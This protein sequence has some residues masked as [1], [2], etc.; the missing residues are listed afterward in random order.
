MAVKLLG[1]STW[2]TQLKNCY[3]VAQG[4]QETDF[5]FLYGSSVSDVEKVA[6]KIEMG[7]KNR[8]KNALRELCSDKGIKAGDIILAYKGPAC[9]QICEV[10][11]DFT[12]VY[13]EQDLDGKPIN[14]YGNGLFPVKW[15]D[16]R[17]VSN[18]YTPCRTADDYG[19]FGIK[20]WQNVNPWKKEDAQE[21]TTRWE[22]YKK[23]NNF[24]PNDFPPEIK[25]RFID[26][27]SSFEQRKKDSY[28]KFTRRSPMIKDSVELLK[29]VYNLV[30]TGA[31]GTGKT[32]L[33]KQIAEELTKDNL[34][35]NTVSVLRAF[36]DNIKTIDAKE[37]QNIL[38][39]WQKYADKIKNETLS[40]P[41]YA[42]VKEGGESLFY[43]IEY[44]TKIFGSCRSGQAPNW[45]IFHQK[46]T[47]EN[48][49]Y[50]N[51]NNQPIELPDAEFILKRQVL[52]FLKILLE[53]QSPKEMLE[54]IDRIEEEKTSLLKVYQCLRK[55]AVL[56]FPTELV[57]IYDKK[58][59]GKILKSLSLPY[60]GDFYTDNRSLVDFLKQKRPHLAITPEVL[61]AWGAALCEPKKEYIDMT[62]F[63][64]SYDYTDF[65]EG[66]RPCYKDGSKEISFE[67]K[68]GTFVKFCEKAA[69]DKDNKYV[70]I[71]DEINRG[72]I[73]KIFGELFAA[74]D[75]GYRG[76][77]NALYIKTQYHNLH[78]GSGDYKDSSFK[79]CFY[80]PD[81]VYIIG[82]MND[83]DRSVES[84]DFALRRRFT[85]KT[86]KAAD[87][88][89]DVLHSHL[90]NDAFRAETIR[91][92]TEINKVMEDKE[93]VGLS[94]IYHIG[95]AYFATLKD[96]SGKEEEKFAQ[97]WKNHL[98]P[99][100]HEYLR[101]MPASD[102]KLEEL[103]K[104]YDKPTQS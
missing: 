35:I 69:T 76:T 41:E 49:I 42:N 28:E 60:T 14:D 94:D 99:L 92:M 34:T 96:Y 77:K 68:Q 98:E 47:A 83:I 19:V 78:E 18:T 8:C 87:R 10:P 59:L 15:V 39:K 13:W 57:G 79:D 62:Q 33:A 52:P 1:A 3:M 95:P 86:I 66:L 9:M 97:L 51:K 84:L 24:D 48:P 22:Q 90:P 21:V 65:V 73:S 36:D 43:F 44:G 93:K 6:N 74:I 63:H 53:K 72:E 32:Y 27:K 75:P 56:Q 82:T 50:R 23:A 25:A 104:A 5:T 55:M 103:K 46:G 54:K 81:N 40:L 85:W 38:A 101:D 67:L 88:A 29:K 45:G 58:I 17:E 37:I 100:L 26:E 16:W 2:Y 71:I 89:E 31:P 7:H 102:D 80:V 11:R 61:C 91:R 12:F 64:P 20:P 4:W 30:L 70:F